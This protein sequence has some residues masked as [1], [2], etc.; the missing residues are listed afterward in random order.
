MKTFIII[1][2]LVFHDQFCL[3]G[4]S[5][6]KRVLFLVA[7]FA[8]VF[9]TIISYADSFEITTVKV[10]LFYEDS[11]LDN[12]TLETDDAFSYGMFDGEFEILGSLEEKILNINALE[13][14]VVINETQ[15]ADG[16]IAIYSND[17]IIKINSVSYRGGVILKAENS[18][19]TVIN[20]VGL[21]EYLYSVIGSEMPS[22]WDIEAL[23]AQAVCARGFAVTNINK[24]LTKGFNLCAT[25]NCQVYKGIVSETESTIKAVDDTKGELLMFEDAP[26]QTLFFS[27]SG[28]H[29]ADVKN[30]WG[31]E[32]EY[33]RGVEDPYEDPETTPRHT[34]S[35]KVS[36]EDIKETL[37]A[38][39][40]DIGE[41]KEL[42]SETDNTGRVYK[43][44]IV[45]TDGEHVLKN[46][47]TA[48]FFGSYGVLSNKY[49]VTPY[50]EDRKELYAKSFKEKKQL[51]AYHVIDANGE[52]K[53]ISMPLTILSQKGKSTI[54]QG[55]PS[56]YIF[57]GGGW[58]HGV[59]MSQYG[60][61]GMAENGFTYDKI[62]YHY[63][64]GTYLK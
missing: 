52:I 32:I 27:C 34:W 1:T 36:N 42:K 51:N 57:N 18:K 25:T 9:L 43:I 33:L 35:A 23:K 7:F 10:G 44:T 38:L 28:G 37:E 20:F 21:D 13:S 15:N 19:L 48:G 56:G 26:A 53:E 54:S 41:I 58:G 55:T 46:S 29:T 22:N 2:I 16:E 17:G 4:G 12:L 62:L 11:A 59:G 24:H 50:G 49:T 63:Y 64:P 3:K 47:G 6:L 5:G 8:A 39:E 31:S 40:V 60:A 45:G 14:T 30:V 61:K